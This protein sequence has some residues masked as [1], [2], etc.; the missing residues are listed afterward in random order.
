MAIY[1]GQV[2]TTPYQAPDYGPSVAAARELAMTQAQ[3]IA[4][5]VG[6]VADYFK[7][8]GDEKKLIKQSD[9]QIDAA[10]K[11]FPE[12][13]S[14]LQ[15]YKDQ[16]RDENIPIADRAFMASQTSDYI[17]NALNMMKTQTQLGI[18]RQREARAAASSGGSSSGGGDSNGTAVIF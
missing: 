5:A 4:G 16:I 17:N 13:S 2:Q 3:G 15:P 7:K 1:G 10:L 11:L 14:V 9:V 8:Q 18:A 6:Q 12:M